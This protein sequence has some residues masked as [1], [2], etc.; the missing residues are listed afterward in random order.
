MESI[1]EAFRDITSDAD[2]IRGKEKQ[3]AVTLAAACLVL[4]LLAALLY[5]TYHRDIDKI[6]AK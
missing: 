4:M 5:A 1:W 3:T 6:I 2:P